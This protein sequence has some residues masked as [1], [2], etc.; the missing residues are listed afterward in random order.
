MSPQVIL[1]SFPGNT[2]LGELWFRSFLQLE[3]DREGVEEKDP[4][5]Q[6]WNPSDSIQY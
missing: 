6:N 1:N 5:C 2:A 4:P 3:G